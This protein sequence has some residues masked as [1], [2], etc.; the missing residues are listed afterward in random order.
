[1]ARIPTIDLERLGLAAALALALVACSPSASTPASP[2]PTDRPT[3]TPSPTIT[4]ESG[5]TKEESAQGHFSVA[6]P[7]KWKR[8]DLDSQTLDAAVATID[9]PQ[10]KRALGTQLQSLSAS[11]VTFV[12]FDF[13]P[14]RATPGFLTNINVI[15]TTLPR[16]YSLDVIAQLSVAQLEAI[17]SVV[18]PIEHAR[19]ELPAGP[20]ERMSYAIST[21]LS[22]GDALTYSVIQYLVLSGLDEYVLT[23]SCSPSSVGIYAPLFEKIARSFALPR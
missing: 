10:M 21:K 13:T 5:W 8:I 20:A 7:P 14:E 17:D 9:D 18:R 22:S 11:G 3:A 15:K 1:M 23:I 4:I 6:L 2:T 16:S 19:V 12:A